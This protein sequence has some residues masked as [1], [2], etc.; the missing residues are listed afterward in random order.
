M[1]FAAA[2][3]IALVVIIRTVSGGPVGHRLLPGVR[4]ARSGS[5]CHELMPAARTDLHR[6]TRNPG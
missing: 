6:P 1:A 4:A 2:A 5:N 3:A